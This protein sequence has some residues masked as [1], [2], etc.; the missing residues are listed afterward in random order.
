MGFLSWLEVILFTLLMFLSGFFSSSET[1]LFS[2]SNVQLEQMRRKKH[3]RVDLIERLLTRPRRLIMTILIG[4]E[5]VN[6][7]A[8]VISAR[9]FIQ[10]L[11]DEYKWVNMLVMVPI[12]LLVG[13]ITPKTLAI[14]NNIAFAGAESRWIEFFARVIKPLRLMIKVIA[15]WF[16]TLIVGKERSRGNII[17]E[18]MVRVLTHEALGEGALDRTE[19]KF[20]E[21]IFDFGNTAIE[22]VM[23]PRSDIFFLPLSRLGCRRP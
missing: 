20:I 13:E 11:G 14:R 17:T 1:A 23:T 9:F 22:E 8:S 15:E 3:P 18:D 5:F 10:M 2:L 21:Q 12:L 19:A 7:F 4:N 6:V 16:I